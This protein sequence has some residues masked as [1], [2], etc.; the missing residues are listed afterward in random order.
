VPTE[1][2]WRVLKFGG[3]SVAEPRNWPRIA[4]EVE[5]RLGEGERVLLVCSALAGMS[6]LL[7]ELFRSRRSPEGAAAVLE[8]FGTRHR[9]LA[10]ELRIGA[11]DLIDAAIDA[12]ERLLPGSP[13]DDPAAR[14][15]GMAF[16]ELL[17]TR[18][19]A[20]WLAGVG[21]PMRWRDARTLLAV[22][23]PPAGASPSQR[24]LCAR[25]AHDPDESLRRDLAGER[26][27]IT[28]GFIA[29]DA[30][31]RTVLL[32]RGGSD[33]AAT[34]LATRLDAV[35]VELFS[36][37][38]GIFTADPRAVPHARLIPRLGTEA[39]ETLAALGAKVI[40]PRCLRPL[41]ARGLPVHLRWTDAP[42]LE[43][44]IIRD[45]LEAR[46]ESGPRAVTSRRQL[47]LVSC[48]RPLERPPVGFI[49]EVA[50]CFREHRISTDLVESTP[51]GVR[52]TIDLT[53]EPDLRLRIL[54]LARDLEANCETHVRD[55]IASVSLVGRGIRSQ[56]DRPQPL[57]DHVRSR[58]RLLFCSAANRSLSL[59]VPRDD[60]GEL[61]ADLHATYFEPGPESLGPRWSDLQALAG[62]AGIL[63][64]A[65][66]G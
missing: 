40:H 21:V 11:D 36:D 6:D 58:Y 18:I 66:H 62:S 20:R 26:A 24:F 48:R 16:G 54:A 64:E 13:P 51:S 46:E 9:A 10:R 4:A 56:L 39:A 28:Q 17:A 52:A 53:A 23:P 32:G 41:R 22:E 45:D 50:K 63:S 34:A 65:C 60:A 15:E 27:V 12:L 35:G 43:G 42:G 29:R 33:V 38:P 61:V 14:A 2:R 8:R 49:A 37:V 31:G 44:T 5:R 59:V 3:T 47:C 30:I 57:L 25:C 7:D 19:G 1:Q 55:E